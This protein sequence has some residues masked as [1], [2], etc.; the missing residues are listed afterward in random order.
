MTIV[1][2]IL[3]V[4]VYSGVAGGAAYYF[5][6]RFVEHRFEKALNEHKHALDEKTEMLKHDLQKD[7]MSAQIAIGEKHKIYAELFRLVNI[8]HGAVFS[9]FGITRELTYEE[10]GEEDFKEL[11]ERWNTPQRKTL[12]LLEL[13][14]S[15]RDKAIKAWREYR[16]V[17]EI[18]EA[19]SEITK[20]RNYLLINEIYMED[21]IAD[22][23]HEILGLIILY[24]TNAEMNEN[25][26]DPYLKQELEKNRERKKQIEDL[27]P[28]LKGTMKSKLL[29]K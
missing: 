15:D 19:R 16:R 28:K 21:D 8:A 5:T 10:Y 6:K 18:G 20:A 13:Y 23:A 11:F 4:L 9:M 7:A 27:L 2:E 26:R 24:L 29:G 12:E 22:M 17:L 14:R 3:R 25:H 1:W